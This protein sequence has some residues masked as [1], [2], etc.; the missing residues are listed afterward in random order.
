MDNGLIVTPRANI[1]RAGAAVGRD[2][3]GDDAQR[4]RRHIV[5]DGQTEIDAMIVRRRTPRIGVV[6]A[7][8]R[9]LEGSSRPCS[10]FHA[11]SFV[12][13]RCEPRCSTAATLSLEKRQFRHS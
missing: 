12:F 2:D 9:C 13:A 6:D 8:L 7:V 11:T 1:A 3:L 5:L 4:I 10:R